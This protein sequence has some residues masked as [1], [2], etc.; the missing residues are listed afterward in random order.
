MKFK[1]KTALA[2]SSIGLLALPLVASADTATSTVS[3]DVVGVISAFTTSGTVTLGAI[4]PDATGRQSTNKDTV[5]ATTND[6]QGLN[7]TLQDSDTTYTLTSGTDTIAK[8]A[9]TYAVPAA[10]ANGEW[11]WR[12]DS[13]GS[14]GVGPTAVLSS[15]APSSLTYAGIPANGAAQQIKNITAEGSTSVEVWYSARVNNTQPSG[16]YTNTVLYTATVN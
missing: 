14:F 10:L 8:A 3:V 16:T 12:V 1:A 9:G 13:L 15:A 5:S 7:I 11:G 6:S 2:V 4:T